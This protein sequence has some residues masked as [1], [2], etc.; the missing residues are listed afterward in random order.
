MSKVELPTAKPET[1]DELN[2]KF[3]RAKEMCALSSFNEEVAKAEKLQACQEILRIKQEQ[4]KRAAAA[5][6]PVA[7]ALTAVPDPDPAPTENQAT[8]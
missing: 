5:K 4:N 7:A 6:Q 3:E 8:T 1:D 2:Q